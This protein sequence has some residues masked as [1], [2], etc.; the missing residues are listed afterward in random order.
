M[1]TKV[2]TICKALAGK[3]ANNIAIIDLSKLSV[4]ADYFVVCDAGST[5]LAKTLSDEVDEKMAEQGFVVTRTE[6]YK[7]G[8]WIVLD[9]N[10][11]IVHIFLKEE[12]EFYNIE[13]L[14]VDGDNYTE[15]KA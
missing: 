12:R 6:G 4:L 13:K 11:V 15:Y 7:E 2:E 10:N 5:T 9:Y 8:R 3:K 14:W 1:D